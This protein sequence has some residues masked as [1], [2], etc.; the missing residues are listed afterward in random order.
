MT[1]KEYKEKNNLTN[2]DLAKLIGLS[3]KNP[4]VS[5]I[6]YLK[7]ERLPH[8]RFMKEISHKTNGLVKPNDFYEAWYEIHK[9]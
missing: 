5:V 8:P 2:K 6:R 4:I 9:L 1:L 3:G 7:S